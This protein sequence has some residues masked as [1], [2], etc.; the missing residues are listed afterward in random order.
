MTFTPIKISK[1]QITVSDFAMCGD[2][3][4]VLD[5]S[6]YIWSCGNNLWGTLGVGDASNRNFFSPAINK[7]KFKKLV[8]GGSSS[9]ALDEYSCAWTWGY[10]NVGQTGYGVPGSAFQVPNRISMGSQTDHMQQWMVLENF[11]SGYVGIDRYD[12]S[13]DVVT[14]GYAWAWGSGGDGA[15]GEGSTTSR[16]MPVSVIGGREFKSLT[17][18][19]RN[20][21]A[22]DSSGYAWAWGYN[23]YGELG[24]NTVISKS[25]PV[26]VLGGI[27]FSQLVSC[28]GSNTIVALDTSSYAWA[29]GYG[30][31]G[32]I[33]ESNTVSRSSPVSVLGGPW[34]K[35]FTLGNYNSAITSTLVGID[36]ADN[37]Y[38]WGSNNNFSYGDGS[39]GD[40]TSP[41]LITYPFKPLKM[42]GGGLNYRITAALDTSSKLWVWG[43]NTYQPLG[44]T[45]FTNVSYPI[46]PTYTDQVYSMIQAPKDIVRDFYLALGGKLLD[47]SNNLWV[48]G[49]N[50]AG[51]LGNDTTTFSSSP[52]SISKK[53]IRLFV[54]SNV[55]IGLDESSYAWA[56]GSNAYGQ[57]GDGT[58][59]N[60]SS[61]VSV[62]GGVQW[63]DISS[64]GTHCVGCDINNGIWCWGYGT[65]GQ[66]GDSTLTSKSSPVSV[67]VGFSPLAAGNSSFCLQFN[68][69]VNAW[70][71]CNVGQL[72][73][74]TLNNYS[75]PLKISWLPNAIA[76]ISS[77]GLTTYAQDVSGYLWS[78]GSN[79]FGQL[80]N[81]NTVG[82]SSPS[83][84][85]TKRFSDIARTFGVGTTHMAA[86][87]ISSYVW[88]WGNNG[89][90][91][92]GDGTISNR[93]VPT[94]VLTSFKFR[95]SCVGLND[96]G[97]YGRVLNQDTWWAYEQYLYKNA[98]FV[99]GFQSYAYFQNYPSDNAVTNSYPVLMTYGNDFVASTV[100]TPRN[101]ILGS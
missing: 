56:W 85:G 86:I 15:L 83:S 53:F 77:S 88:S 99:T 81:N 31:G 39:S 96:E 67:D 68:G 5:S 98:Y 66:I 22:L 100:S 12:S 97:I 28:V 41:R 78:W 42:A 84:I 44:I 1:K 10:N 18:A 89:S 87:D 63:I 25:S 70:G 45:P 27:V 50:V 61:P 35:I 37:C 46:A 59:N 9:C 6:G 48:W 64:S 55:T 72:G 57:L 69:D 80:G 34:K 91:R 74:N 58:T 101:N 8:F 24:D 76:K 62:L 65:S 33:G 73:F 36:S 17:A 54:N 43:N 90:G 19:S 4:L 14:S 16:S 51:Q 82:T 79:V 75:Y 47:Y 92:L 2:S 49:N 94:S 95:E 71:S 11:G 23:Q 30:G 29:W 7:T 40:A 13:G 60:R 20:V 52:V 21:V 3:L 38:I 26:S 32:Q 93:S